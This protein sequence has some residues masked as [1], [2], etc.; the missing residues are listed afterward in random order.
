MINTLEEVTRIKSNRVYSTIGIIKRL[1]I[2]YKLIK[3]I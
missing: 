2:I 1:V 3:K